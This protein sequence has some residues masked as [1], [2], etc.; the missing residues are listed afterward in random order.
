MK[1]G[2]VV[3]TGREECRA[4][5]QG[6][7]KDGYKQREGR[8]VLTERGREGERERGMVRQSKCTLWWVDSVGLINPITLLLKSQLG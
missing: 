2:R 6:G 4:H 5:M 8:R 1:G 3:K 7:S